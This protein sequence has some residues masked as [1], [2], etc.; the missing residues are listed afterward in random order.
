[1]ATQHSLPSRTLPLYLGRAFTGWIAPAFGWRTHSITSSARAKQRGWGAALAAS[2]AGSPPAVT[3][4]AT[5][6]RADERLRR[7][8]T[9]LSPEHRQVIDLVYYHE[10]S[11]DEVAQIL[12][13]PSATVKTRMFYTRKKLAEFLTTCSSYSPRVGRKVMTPVDLLE[14][15]KVS[16]ISDEVRAIVAPAV[17]ER[18]RANDQRSGAELAQVGEG[19]I[20][21]AF[22]ACVNNMD[23]L[24]DDASRVFHTG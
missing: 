20:E 7:A 15:E 19:S 14:M 17:E 22:G 21:L 10:K 4:T 6:P 9:R 24:A 18:I 23:L 2:A 12:D 13:V 3:R 8:L 1:V 5:G 16:V 11:V